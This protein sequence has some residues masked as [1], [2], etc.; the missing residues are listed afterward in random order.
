MGCNVST[1]TPGAS[2]QGKGVVENLTWSYFAGVNGRGDVLRQMFEYRGQPHT[3]I[4]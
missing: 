2:N 3:F 4:G 1:V